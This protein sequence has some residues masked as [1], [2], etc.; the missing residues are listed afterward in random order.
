[1]KI[2]CGTS[3]AHTS[4]ILSGTS[5]DERMNQKPVLCDLAD[6][7]CVGR[8]GQKECDSAGERTIPCG[9]KYED[10]KSR[11]VALDRRYFHRLVRAVIEGTE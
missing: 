6:V 7:W 4:I 8:S 2:S 9:R 10:K 5:S 3:I 1:M 11:V